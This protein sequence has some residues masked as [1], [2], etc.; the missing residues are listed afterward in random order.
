MRHLPLQIVYCLLVSETVT[1]A[2]CVLLDSE[3][4]NISIC[5]CDF[6]ACVEYQLYV[7]VC[8]Y[9]CMHDH[10]FE[11]F[12]INASIQQ[13][14]SI[15]TAKCYLCATHFPNDW[16]TNFEKEISV[17]A[18]ALCSVLFPVLKNIIVCLP[19]LLNNTISNCY[20]IALNER[21]IGE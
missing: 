3:T 11:Q 8:V 7:N 21:I 18:L 20:C 17:H 9:V 13:Y 19:C 2:D 1:I 12:K 6:K 14:E 16:F 15:L 4:Y 10:R 5:C